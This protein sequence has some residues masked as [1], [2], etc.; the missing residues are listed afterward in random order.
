MNALLRS[1]ALAAAGFAAASLYRQW[2]SGAQSGSRRH[3]HPL[4]TWEN[5]GGALPDSLPADPGSTAYP[6]ATSW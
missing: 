2:Q 4:E 6:K 5:E 1:L 3:R